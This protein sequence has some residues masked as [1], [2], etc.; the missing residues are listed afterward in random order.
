M[1]SQYNALL[2]LL[3]AAGGV[4]IVPVTPAQAAALAELWEAGLV[5]TDGE[6][7]PTYR[8]TPGGDVALTGLG[9]EAQP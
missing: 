9:V 1:L 4:G 2:D 8:R 5:S 6:D 3:V 7:P